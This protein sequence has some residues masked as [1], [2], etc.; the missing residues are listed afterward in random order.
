MLE[1]E[2]QRRS[3]IRNLFDGLRKSVPS[4]EALE[5]TS[6]R[7]IL[8]EAA[9]HIEDLSHQSDELEEAL[10]ELRAENARLREEKGCKYLLRPYWCT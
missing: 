8:L 3:T 7:Q 4:L 1:R 9:K 6:D 2:R 5:G 10:K